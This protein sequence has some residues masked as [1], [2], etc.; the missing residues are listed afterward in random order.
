MNDLSRVN[1]ILMSNIERLETLNI[2]DKSARDEIMR[3]N[4]I[5][6]TA[7]AIVQIKVLEIN[8]KRLSEIK[9]GNTMAKQG[10]E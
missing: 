5:S 7:K 6:S 9:N 4:S 3:S 1:E 2:K 8:M 10:Q